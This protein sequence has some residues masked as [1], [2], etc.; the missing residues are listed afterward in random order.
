M[1][2]VTPVSCAMICWVR[3]AMRADSSVGKASASSSEFVC[4]DWQPP[5]TAARAC[6]ATRMIL[7][8]G[9]WAVSEDPAVCAW[10]RKSS[11]RGSFAWKR[12]R[13]ILAHRRRAARYLAISS[14]RSLW[15][16]KKK[17]SCG[18]NSSTRSE[19]HTSELQSR[20]DLVCRLLLEKKKEK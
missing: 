15:A 7:F 4:K 12:S 3:R 5:R 10:K 14:R 8:S 20:R 13:M 17:E 19:E 18:A 16:L 2:L 9:C 11:E 6:I 1:V